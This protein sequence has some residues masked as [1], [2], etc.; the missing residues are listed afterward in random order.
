MNIP[1]Y[2]GNHQTSYPHSYP[3]EARKRPVQFRFAHTNCIR[4]SPDLQVLYKYAVRADVIKLRHQGEKLPRAQLVGIR[5]RL[6][7]ERGG[8]V[9]GLRDVAPYRSVIASVHTRWPQPYPGHHEARLYDARITRLDE[10]GF[11]LI[12]KE[13][14][15]NGLGASTYLQAWACVPVSETAAEPP[16]PASP[17]P[18]PGP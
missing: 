4:R 11:V 8:M 9:E 12:G 18:L 1:R 16:C 10:R 5:G 3:Q 7:I 15:L 2:L 14:V 13:V 17:P 6:R